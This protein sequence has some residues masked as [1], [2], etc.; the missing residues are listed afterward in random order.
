MCNE[1]NINN[2]HIK[3]IKNN[4]YKNLT[5][6]FF[7]LCSIHD[8]REWKRPAIKNWKKK[9]ASARSFGIRQLVKVKVC[10]YMH[11]AIYIHTCVLYFFFFI[12]MKKILKFCLPTLKCW[13]HHCI[14]MSLSVQS[15]VRTPLSGQEIKDSSNQPPKVNFLIFAFNGSICIYSN[16]LACVEC[17]PVKRRP[18]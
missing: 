4:I 16:D 1:I 10:I 7:R 14:H 18:F 8:K 15:T 13:A 6:R 3:I 17:G 9:S 12:F 11:H 5:R 2:Y